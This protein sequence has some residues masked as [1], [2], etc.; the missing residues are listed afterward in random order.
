MANPNALEQYMLELINRM[1]M[2]PGAE[3]DILV[4]SSNSDNQS[5][6]GYFKDNLTQ[7]KSQRDKLK[8]AQPVAWSNQLHDSAVAHTQLMIANDEQSH[9]FPNQPSLGDSIRN[10]GYQFTTVAENIYAYGSSVFESHGAFAIDWG[11]DDNNPNNGYGTGIQNPPAHRNAIM[12]NNYREVGIGIL[13]EDNPSTRV[14]SLLTTQHFANSQQLENNQE[15]WL[16]GAAFLDIDNDNFYSLGEGLSNVTL[17][18]SGVSNPSFQ[19]KLNTLTAGGYQT[20]LSPGTYRI[21]FVAN[22]KTFQTSNVTIDNEN[23]KLDLNIDSQ[24]YQLDDGKRNG[25]YDS[26]NGD[27]IIFNAFTASDAQTINFISVAQSELSNPKAVFLYQDKDGDG[28]PDANEKLLEVSANLVDKNGFANIPINST[29]VEGTFFVGAL[30]EGNSLQTT[31]IPQDNSQ[32]EGK[33]WIATS[34]ANQFNSESFSASLTNDRNWFLRASGAIPPVVGEDIPDIPLNDESIIGT[35]LQI[36]DGIELI[37]LTNQIGTVK[38]SVE[39]TRD[40][41]YDNL[42]GFYAIHNA[43]GGIKVNDEIINP[44][45][46]RYKQAVL[47]NRITSLDLLHTSN[48]AEFNG[49]F[50]GGSIFAP[51]IIVDATLNQ[52]LNNSAE[53]YFAFSSAN[54]DKFDHIRLLGDNIFGFE[55]LPNGGD[56]DYNDLIIEMK[57]TA[58]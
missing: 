12:S 52:A 15:S 42:I 29:T 19:R 17:N 51:F 30:Y 45:D 56:K 40:A 43:D 31:W 47:E 2:N 50:Q 55:D 34:E 54:T 8:P 14:G 46:S 44:D 33:S 37:D 6:L 27:T 16:L 48:Q 21:E 18:I 23:V 13:R 3:Y 58:L 11:D 10:T 7:L 57:F 32:P 36:S 26:G 38:T 53:L 4:N 20:L 1:R 25:H 35:A 5:A 41:D 22:G 9:N 28:S 49:T 39:V 24:T